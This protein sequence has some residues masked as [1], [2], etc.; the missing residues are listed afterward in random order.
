MRLEG[1]PCPACSLR[2]SIDGAQDAFRACEFAPYRGHR[3]AALAD[4]EEGAQVSVTRRVKNNALAEL[5]MGDALAG[6]ILGRCFHAPTS[7]DPQVEQAS[8]LAALAQKNLLGVLIGFAPQDAAEV[9]LAAPV[10]RFT[11]PRDRIGCGL[12]PQPAV[13]ERHPE[14]QRCL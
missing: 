1:Q 13:A 14:D 11:K 7:G 12:N 5:V 8:C 3:N 10:G 2:P 9:E 6:L 4:A